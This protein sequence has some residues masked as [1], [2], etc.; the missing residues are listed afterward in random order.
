LLPMSDALKYA[1]ETRAR[2]EGEIVLVDEF[3]NHR[4]EPGLVDEIGVFLAKELAPCDAIVTS[5][6]SGIAPAYAVAGALGVDMVFAK[7]RPEPPSGALSRKIVS[8]TKGDT[9][10]LVLSPRSIAGLAR[11]AIVDDFLWGGR[12]ALALVEMLREAGIEVAAA[13]FCVEKT[14]GD[15]RR[16]LEEAGIRVVAAAVITGIEK[17]RPVVA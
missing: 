9:T 16:L 13:G 17:G 14:F 15:G 12:T 5:E 1:I 4:V 6:A 11:V 2:V 7:K 10:W 8:P 3:L